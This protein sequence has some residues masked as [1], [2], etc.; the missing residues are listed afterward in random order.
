MLE[1]LARF[2]KYNNALPIGIS[3]ILVGGSAAF[4]TSP[5]VR[6]TFVSSNDV[7]R[8]VD[9]S[10]I[11]QVDISTFDF[12]LQINN[13]MED[14]DNYYVDYSYQSIVLDDYVWQVQTIEKRLT[15]SKIALNE[16]YL[17]D[18]GLYVSKEIGDALEA[19]IQYLS[20]V[21][22]LERNKGLSNKIVTTE[23]TGLIGKYFNT[24]DKTFPGYAAV[25]LSSREREEG[26]EQLSP[27]EMR[28]RI[29]EIL[30][31]RQRLAEE[32]RLKLEQEAA[33]A[34]VQAESESE[35]EQSPEPSPEPQPEQSPEPS[36][37]PQPEPSPESTPSPEPEPTP[38]PETN[39][40]GDG[41]SQTVS[42]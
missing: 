3:L 37:E 4:A 27:E 34:A 25:I 16:H 12:N 7:V 35:S 11:I 21:Q 41:E 5:E 31:E 28:E 24:R 18:L 20:R 36:P 22:T 42:N 32:E 15:V 23:Y 40:E 10:F 2:I 29:R 38:E 13:V 1:R 14:N 39:S 26:P 8:S 19:E 33:Q 6:E 30:L 17:K 9:N